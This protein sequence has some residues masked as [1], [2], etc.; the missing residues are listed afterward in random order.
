MT[1]KQEAIGYLDLLIGV[2]E[3]HEKAL[4]LIVEKLEKVIAKVNKT[5]DRTGTPEERGFVDVIGET[6]MQLPKGY[7]FNIKEIRTMANVEISLEEKTT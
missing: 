4:D 2:L 3:E 7:T 6:L 5:P 1:G